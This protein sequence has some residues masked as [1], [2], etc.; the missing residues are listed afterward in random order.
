MDTERQ[1]VGSRLEAPGPQLLPEGHCRKESDERQLSTLRPKWSQHT[2]T[3]I[4]ASHGRYSQPRCPPGCSRNL[5]S[6]GQ[7]T[8]LGL[9]P[10]LSQSFD[11]SI[12]DYSTTCLGGL[13]LSG[14][15]S[16]LCRSPLPLIGRHVHR[17]D[18]GVWRTWVQIP[19][20]PPT[21]VNHLD[22]SESQSLHL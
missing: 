7:P 11:P 9:V 1:A 19:A 12:L 13:G 10:W 21:W 15:P 20:H 6:L 5:G 4:P 16:V 8:H 2:D 22:L 18:H 17:W 14:L 3:S